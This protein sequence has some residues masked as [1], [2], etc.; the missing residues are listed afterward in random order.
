MSQDLQQQA[1]AGRRRDRIA[2]VLMCL[3]P[4]LVAGG[5][6]TPGWISHI[7]IAQV[8]EPERGQVADRIGPYGHRPILIPRDFSQGFRPEL[9]D[10]D[11]LFLGSRTRVE[12]GDSVARVNVFDRNYGDVIAFDDMGDIDEPI[13]FKDALLEEPVAQLYVDQEVEH[14]LPLCGTLYAG[15]CVRD[16]DFSGEVVLTPQPIPEPETALLLWVGLL[17]LAWQGRRRG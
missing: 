5:F 6:L 14:A 16:D 10:L 8:D 1:R 17:G 11:Q 3:F 13:E 15:N 4:L 12:P 7:A 9:L 2:V